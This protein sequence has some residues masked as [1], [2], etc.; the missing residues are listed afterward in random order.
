MFPVTVINQDFVKKLIA[1]DQ[2]LR[3]GGNQNCHPRLRKGVAQGLNRRGGQDNVPDAVR[4]N[5]KNIFEDHSN[6]LKFMPPS[7]VSKFKTPMTSSTLIELMHVWAA[8][9]LGW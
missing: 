4:P 6:C 9:R 7:G 2:V 8:R 1:F 3:P 5:D